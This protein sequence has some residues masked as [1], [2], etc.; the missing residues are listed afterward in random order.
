[1]ECD[2]TANQPFPVIHTRKLKKNDGTTKSQ[3]IYARLE[4]DKSSVLMR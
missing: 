1:M 4:A 2:T 3:L